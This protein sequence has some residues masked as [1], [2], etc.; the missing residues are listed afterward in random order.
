MSSLHNLKPDR[1]IKAY[2]G[3]GTRKWLKNEGT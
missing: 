1:V 3:Q 2:E